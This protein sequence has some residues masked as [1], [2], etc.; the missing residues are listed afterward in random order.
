MD[1]ARVTRVY[2]IHDRTRV[3]FL[4]LEPMDGCPV[5]SGVTK[6]KDSLTR[7]LRSGFGSPWSPL[8]KAQ[9]T[10]AV[11]RHQTKDDQRMV[12]PTTKS[13]SIRNSATRTRRPPGSHLVLLTTQ[14]RKNQS[15]KVETP[16]KL[17][18]KTKRSHLKR[19]G[20][21]DHMERRARQNILDPASGP[22]SDH[23]SCLEPSKLVH[24]QTHFGFMGGI[25]VTNPSP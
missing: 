11:C 8:F 5:N 22:A 13:K 6:R 18:R 3:Q 24:G 19:G 20:G 23:N 21:R 25:N 14:F 10:P 17:Q 15:Q 4:D 7:E 16:N 9:L 12:P 2:D 1:P